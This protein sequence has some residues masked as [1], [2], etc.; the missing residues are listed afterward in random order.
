M[1]SINLYTQLQASN[2]STVS[3]TGIWFYAGFSN[4]TCVE[5]TAPNAITG[6]DYNGIN[7]PTS[8]YQLG[9]TYNPIVN[10]QNN[11][12]YEYHYFRYELTGCLNPMYVCVH[13]VDSG[14][15]VNA[16][17]GGCNCVSQDLSVLID[18]ETKVPGYPTHQALINLNN[19]TTGTALTT[20]P[21]TIPANNTLTIPVTILSTMF[22][23]AHLGINNLTFTT[24]AYPTGTPAC[25]NASPTVYP[26]LVYDNIV[27]YYGYRY[28]EASL[29]SPTPS[30]AYVSGNLNGTNIPSFF[31][32][33][34]GGWDFRIML[35]QHF[36]TITEDPINELCITDWKL[37]V[38]DGWSSGAGAWDLSVPS[39]AAIFNPYFNQSVIGSPF[40]TNM[41]NLNDYLVFRNRDVKTGGN[42]FEFIFKI[43]DVGGSTYHF[44]KFNE[45]GTYI[46]LYKAINYTWSDTGASFSPKSAA[47]TIDNCDG[48]DLFDP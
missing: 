39:A 33:N 48:S 40:C 22:N 32:P 36:S 44:F 26:V 19:Q 30:I 27:K 4:G 5:H 42:T 7:I 31:L 21:H 12:P 15:V 1:L 16:R 13:V 9:T 14:K 18:V 28:P 38:G 3:T 35:L 47:Y 10:I 45:S 37:L 34:L 8:M 46:Q 24:I 23:T 2:T 43:S 6:L 17:Y 20:G 25:V 11:V 29:Y 41:T